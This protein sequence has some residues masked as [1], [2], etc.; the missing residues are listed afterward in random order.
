MAR[1]ETAAA[2]RS[3][4]SPRQRARRIRAIQYVVLVV[5]VA[6]AVWFADWATIGESFFDPEL[7]KY[8]LLNGFLSAIWHTI[9]YSAGGFVLGLVAGTLLALMR[10]SD[11][12]P[13]RWLATIYIEFFRGLPAGKLDV[14]RRQPAVR[15]DTGQI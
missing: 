15:C 7:I 12:A 8:T 4:L 9:A 3:R 2:G 6:C 14:N 11:V 1:N 10:L 13:Y 5:I